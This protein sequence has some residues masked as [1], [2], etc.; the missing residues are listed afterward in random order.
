M[1]TKACQ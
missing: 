1:T